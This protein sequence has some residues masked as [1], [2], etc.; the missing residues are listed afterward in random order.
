MVRIKES[1]IKCKSGHRFTSPIFFGS[2]SAFET[3]TTSGNKAQCPTCR[4][5]V[6]CNKTNMSY[7]LEGGQG[8]GVGDDFGSKK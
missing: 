4:V 3:A 1:F 5:M 8:G 7:V 2:V 6:D